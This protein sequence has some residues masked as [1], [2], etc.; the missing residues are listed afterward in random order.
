MAMHA[1]LNTASAGYVFTLIAK[2]DLERFWI[3]Y[4]GVWLAAGVLTVALTRG[5]PGRAEA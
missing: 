3:I 1:V 4:A 2:S 5:T